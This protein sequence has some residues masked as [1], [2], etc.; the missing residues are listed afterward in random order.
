MPNDIVIGS[1]QA[2]LYDISVAYGVPM[3]ELYALN[4]QFQRGTTDGRFSEAIEKQKILD[5]A[6]KRDGDFI[7]EG[8]LISLPSTAK[9]GPFY[10]Y[11]S[12]ISVYQREAALKHVAKAEQNKSAGGG[13]SRDEF[14][15]A[16]TKAKGVSAREAEDL[17]HELARDAAHVSSGEE[18]VAAGELAG[19]LKAAKKAADSERAKEAAAEA[20]RKAKQEAAQQTAEASPGGTPHEVSAADAKGIWAKAYDWLGEKRVIAGAN[21]ANRVTFYAGWATPQGAKHPTMQWLGKNVSPRTGALAY[22]LAQFFQG[23][24]PGSDPLYSGAKVAEMGVAAGLYFNSVVN[25][26]ATRG[27]PAD[28]TRMEKWLSG[29][30]KGQDL[31]NFVSDMNKLMEKNPKAAESLGFIERL[32]YGAQKPGNT[33]A[34]DVVIKGFTTAVALDIANLATKHGDTVLRAVDSDTKNDPSAAEWAGMGKDAAMS[35]G[36]HAPLLMTTQMGRASIKAGFSQKAMLLEKAAGEASRATYFGDLAKRTLATGDHALAKHFEAQ[37]MH[38]QTMEKQTKELA[39]KVVADAR[40]VS[41]KWMR[42]GFALM[43]AAFALKNEA[44]LVKA[45]SEVAKLETAL[46]SAAQGGEERQ[47]ISQALNELKF[48]IR[49]FEDSRLSNAVNVA[50]HVTPAALYKDIADLVLAVGMPSLDQYR[51]ARS[52]LGL[53]PVDAEDPLAGMFTTTSPSIYFTQ[54]VIERTASEIGH[55]SPED[56]LYQQK[57][58]ES[59]RALVKAFGDHSAELLKYFKPVMLPPMMPLPIRLGLF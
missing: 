59:T 37:K 24:K 21:G 35:L 15:A 8:E 51:K 56:I 31:A 41:T 57:V 34:H 58:A 52:D 7:Q 2:S 27:S 38:F 54:K 32:V 13:L 10:F 49:S 26:L 43:D 6:G 30:L 42:G 5:H 22:G 17:F 12:H 33:F 53:P 55:E 28:F 29:Q 23:S 3:G 14:I 40:V 46:Q 16:A 20:A 1:S 9:D 44:D 48:K 11:K 47:A 19:G 39:E 25:T 36:K 45:R 4:P 50:A 18:R